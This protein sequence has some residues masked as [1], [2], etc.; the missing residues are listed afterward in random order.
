LLIGDVLKINIDGAF[1]ASSRTGGWGFIVHDSDGDIRG[2]GVGHLPNVA[3]AA[4]AEAHAC[5]EAVAAAAGWGM[6]NVHF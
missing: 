3:S 5:A 4:Q 1:H 2:S 6:T